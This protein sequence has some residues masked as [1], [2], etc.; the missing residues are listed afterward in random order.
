MSDGRSDETQTPRGRSQKLGPREVARADPDAL[1]EEFLYHLS[2]GSEF[3]IA[4]EVV[5]AKEELERA[6]SYRPL[7]ARSQD[8]LASVYFRLGVY[9]RAIEIWNALVHS[10][11]ED[12]AL[13]VNLGLALLKTA[14]PELALSHLARAVAKDP[15][16]ERAWRYVGLAEWRVGNLDR[17]REAFLRGGQA[18]MARRMEEMLGSS[19]TSSA[20]SEA[21]PYIESARLSLAPPALVPSAPDPPAIVS[22]PSEDA[23]EEVAD[24]V[25][26]GDPAGSLRAERMIAGLSV[27][28]APSPTRRTLAPAPFAALPPAELTPSAPARVSSPPGALSAESMAGE[29]TFAA[30]HDGLL[31]LRPWRP[32]LARRSRLRAVVGELPVDVVR[33]ADGP[34]GSIGE[35]LGHQDP[36]HRLAGQRALHYSPFGSPSGG[37]GERFELLSLEDELFS[38]LER[39]LFAFDE[40]LAFACRDL[41][42]TTGP[43]LPLVELRGTGTCALVVER[44]PTKLVV[45]EADEVRVGAQA[46]VGWTGRLVPS[47][48]EERWVSLRGEGVVYFT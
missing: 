23:P 30:T 45:R 7:D 41:T 1:E 18:S 47:V 27:P 33:R 10:H 31:V 46:L 14:Q 13:R 15:A 48:V 28:P 35:P 21:A 20:G 12:V 44:I 9:P 22:T 32:I 8:L 40:Q 2:R 37:N 42:A 17:A 6:L 19:S 36:F 29:P 39:A 4:N 11:G 34:P 24:A 3:L 16:H 38:V 43:S 26:Y 25:P 5:Q